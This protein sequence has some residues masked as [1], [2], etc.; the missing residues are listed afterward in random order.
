MIHGGSG[1]YYSTMSEQPVD[2]QLYNGQNVIGN[3]YLN[4][5]LPG[6]VGD[7]TRGVTAA[8][9]LAEWSR[10]QRVF[11]RVFPRGSTCTANDF[12]ETEEHDV[13]MVE[14]ARG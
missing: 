5:R 8:Q 7:P 9:V 2:Q 11:W 10:M 3:T 4:D 6:F 1:I 14:A 13:V 12:V